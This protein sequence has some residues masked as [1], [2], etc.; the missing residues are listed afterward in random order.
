MK[1]AIG[2][3][4]AAALAVAAVGAEKFVV[5]TY[6]SF[7]RYGPAAAIERAFEDRFPGVD[8]VWVAP[9]GGRR[10]SPVSSPNSPPEGRTPTCSWGSRRP[11]SPAP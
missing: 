8:L 7:V 4:A 2:I 1:Y 6:R 10:C 9:A 3:L 5:Y 11:T